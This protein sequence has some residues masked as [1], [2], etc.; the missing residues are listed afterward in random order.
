MRMKKQFVTPRVVQEVRVQLEQDL[1]QKSILLDTTAYSEGQGVGN[2]DVSDPT[3]ENASY[4]A[5]W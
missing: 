3:D 2:Y 5:E 1:L 4:F